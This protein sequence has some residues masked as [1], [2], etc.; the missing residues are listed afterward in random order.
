MVFSLIGNILGAKEGRKGAESAANAQIQAAQLGVDEQKRQ[1]NV[2]RD[3]LN[4]FVQAGTERLD[5]VG[6]FVKYGIPSGDI[7]QRYTETGIPALEQQEVLA[8]LRGPEEQ[9]AA[10]EAIK[11]GPEYQALADA[12]EEG[13][14]RQGSAAGQLRGGRTQEALFSARPDILSGLVER[15]YSRLGGLSGMGGNVAQ[16]LMKTGQGAAQD[17]VLG[18][19]NAAAGVGKA[20]MQTGAAISD[21][22]QQ[23]GAAQAGLAKE[24]AKNRGELFSLGADVFQDIGKTYVDQG[25]KFGSLGKFGGYLAGGF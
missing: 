13:V 23:Q 9:A 21:L 19:Q 8:G 11:A 4:P 25:G 12:A 16:Q 2:L 5:D 7:L 17:L 14:L 1:F 6:E 20:A 10:I 24:M 15:Q 3:A 22:M 18:G